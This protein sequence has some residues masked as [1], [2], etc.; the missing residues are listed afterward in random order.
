MNNSQNNL[1]EN[2]NG[3]NKKNAKKDKQKSISRIQI[4][5]LFTIII[6]IIFICLQKYNYAII[7]SVISLIIIIGPTIYGLIKNHIDTKI[8]ILQLIQLIVAIINLALSIFRPNI[9]L[10]NPPVTPTLE[11]KEPTETIQTSK[12]ASTLTPTPTVTPTPTPTLTPMPTSTP[13]NY[14]INVCVFDLGLDENNEPIVKTNVDNLERLGFNVKIIN[15]DE[16]SSYE[17]CEVLY[18]SDGWA[19]IKNDL[20]IVQN[21]ENLKKKLEEPN[22]PGLLIGNPGKDYTPFNIDFYAPIN[23]CKISTER[24]EELFPPDIREENAIKYSF[25]SDFIPADN[26]KLDE[27]KRK[28]LPVPES[29]ASIEQDYDKPYSF[30]FLV[31][32]NQLKDI[33]VKKQCDNHTVIGGLI[34]SN[35]SQNNPR[36]IIMPGGEFS[37][38]YPISDDLFVLIIK[39]L[40]GISIE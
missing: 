12:S 11:T 40:A 21:M 10:V 32:G 6:S 35:E 23:Y 37:S 3:D 34:A 33:T 25:L 27:E 14:V 13:T 29:V 24:I 9:I 38:R 2:E 17:G 26:V 5:S 28:E 16:K 20:K 4:I 19:N 8:N 30:Q 18:L 1:S 7:F 36:Y 31:V 22:A 39:W 15:I